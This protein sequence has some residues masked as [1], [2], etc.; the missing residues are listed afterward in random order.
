MSNDREQVI[1]AIWAQRFYFFENIPVIFD[2]MTA[3]VWAHL[4]EYPKCSRAYNY[5]QVKAFMRET[6]ER[7]FGGFNDWKIPTPPELWK[8]VKE[9]TFPLQEG[10][11]WRILEQ[12]FWCVND[13]GAIS[14]KDLDSEGENAAIVRNHDVSVIPCSHALVP[15]N[16]RGTAQE[17][18]DIFTANNLVPIFNDSTNT[19][20]YKKIFVEK[21]A[22]ESEQSAKPE[23][24]LTE[25]FD[26]KQLLTRYNVAE[27]AA[28]PIKYFDAVTDVA[29]TLLEA[30]QNYETAQSETIR[31]FSQAALKLKTK[32]ADNPNLTDDEKA[33]LAERQ[34]FLA[35]RLELQTDEPKKQ[36]LSLKTQ[37]ENFFTR[38]DEINDGDNSVRELIDLQSEPRADFAFLVENYIRLINNAQAKLDFF[39]LHK[40][41]VLKI[42]DAWETWSNDY[43]IFKTSLREELAAKCHEDGIDD[44]IF[45]ELYEDW[46]TKRFEIEQKF[47]PLV[48]FAL[49]GKLLDIAE[50]VLTALH[51]YRDEVDKFYLH[52]RKIVY[53]NCAFKPNGDLQEKFETESKIYSCTENFQRELQNI[54]FAC[55]KTEERIFLLKWAESLLNLSVAEI[56]KFVEDSALDVVSSEMLTQFAALRRQNFATYLADAKAFSDALKQ[57]EEE[58]NRL[59]YRMRSGLNKR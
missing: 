13:N 36:I 55:D 2:G 34:E 3:L 32:P 52:E 42:V 30:L 19:E 11:G 40:D 1:H 25:K 49:K 16:F 20:L 27:L 12:D 33:L 39:I 21:S 31:E 44:E 59:L 47:L 26:G 6:N 7:Y 57:R 41:F 48:K 50:K 4:K 45:S 46:R 38:L 9:K 51:K 18:L 10:Y 8:L 43:K 23:I 5:S 58:F 24:K 14:A 37:A 56:L 28:S 22:P 29:D 17:I 54:I 15:N 35:R 53:Q